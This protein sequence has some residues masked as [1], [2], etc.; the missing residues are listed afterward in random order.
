MGYWSFTPEQAAAFEETVR[1][2]HVLD[3]GAGDCSLSREALRLGAKSVLAVD[4]DLPWKP[5]VTAWRGHFSG[6][7]ASLGPL[8][9][10]VVIVSWPATCRADGLL[11]LVHDAQR[12]IVLAKTTDGVMCGW[13]W[14][15][16][17]LSTRPIDIRVPD[18]RNTLLVY[19]AGVASRPPAPEERQGTD[20][21]SSWRY[22]DADD[23]CLVP[24]NPSPRN[25]ARC[26]TCGGNR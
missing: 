10:D 13:P 4:K 17:Y 25:E 12:V 23:P 18:R 11:A 6:L 16:R 15:W 22:S 21:V 3:L 20:E 24:D 19:G 7:V 14:L 1:G 5:G 26:S 9:S 8:V 2:A